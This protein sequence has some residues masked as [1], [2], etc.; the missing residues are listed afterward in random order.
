MQYCNTILIVDEGVNVEALLSMFTKEH[1]INGQAAYP[2]EHNIFNVDAGK[3]DLRALHDTESSVIRFICR[4]ERELP[5]YERKILSFADKY[6]ISV[7][8]A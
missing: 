7:K 1:F 8:R 3:N 6:N 4:Y 2:L 5:V